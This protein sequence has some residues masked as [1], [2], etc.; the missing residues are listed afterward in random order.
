MTE[1][2]GFKEV[3]III[4]HCKVILFFSQSIEKYKTF[5]HSLESKLENEQKNIKFILF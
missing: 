5:I 2:Q 3:A 1:N 4:F